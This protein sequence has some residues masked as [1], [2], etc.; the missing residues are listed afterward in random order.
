MASPDPSG[1]NA[2]AVAGRAE[3][4]VN[5]SGRQQPTFLAV[6]LKR[7]SG[8]GRCLDH[9]HN[10]LDLTEV[11]N[12]SLTIIHVGDAVLSYGRKTKR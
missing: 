6:L 8:I 9:S 1:G 7:G 4:D 5:L 3:A 10:S 12:E 2:V 11:T